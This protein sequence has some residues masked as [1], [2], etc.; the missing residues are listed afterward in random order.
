LDFQPQSAG[1]SPAETVNI[2]DKIA[3]VV[4]SGMWKQ[5]EAKDGTYNYF[6]LLDTLEILMVRNENNRRSIEY[7]K[8]IA[9]RGMG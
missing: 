6:D 2:D 7:A 1:Y 5:K 9:N 4:A 8:Q 3:A